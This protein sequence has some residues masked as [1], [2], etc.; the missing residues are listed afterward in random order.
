MDENSSFHLDQLDTQNSVFDKI[1]GRFHAVISCLKDKRKSL[2]E[3]LMANHPC[4]RNFHPSG[5]APGA[6]RGT[7]FVMEVGADGRQMVTVFEGSYEVQIVN[8]EKPLA[9]QAGECVVVT[10]D[11]RVESHGPIEPEKLQRWWRIAP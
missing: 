8:S 9:V 3:A 6:V 4:I 2:S 1:T 7:E 10:A 5:G 11:G